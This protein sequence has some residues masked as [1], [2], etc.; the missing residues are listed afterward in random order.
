[1]GQN[2]LIRLKEFAW[3]YLSP[4]VFNHWDEN[5]LYRANT[6]RYSQSYPIEGMVLSAITAS[7]SGDEYVQAPSLQGGVSTEALAA[8]STNL[9]Y[10]VTIDQR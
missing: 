9:I 7:L 8:L 5:R 2:C 6:I 4:F 3:V 10:H 1:M